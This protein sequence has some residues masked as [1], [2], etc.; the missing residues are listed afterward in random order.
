M[1]PEASIELP[2]PIKA[3]GEYTLK[4]TNGESGTRRLET[5]LKISV[6]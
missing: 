6:I 5:D 2:K 4:L 1:V 3:K